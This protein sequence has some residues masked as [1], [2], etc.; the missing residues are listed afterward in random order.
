MRHIYGYSAALMAMAAAQLD[1]LRLI[2]FAPT[3]DFSAPKRRRTGKNYPH[4]STRQQARYA[5][6]LA[7]GQIKFTA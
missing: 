7:A 3:A 6:Q 4:S 1:A 5:R 2:S